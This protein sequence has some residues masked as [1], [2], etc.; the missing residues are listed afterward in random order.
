MILPSVAN[1]VGDS[2]SQAE[3]SDSLGLNVML[4]NRSGEMRADG[5][6]IDV[7][8]EGILVSP[9]P[10]FTLKTKNRENVKVFINICYNDM[11]EKQSKKKKLDETGKEIEGL[12]LPLSMGSMRTCNDKAENACIVVDAIVNTSIRDDISND[13]SGCHRDVVCQVLINCFDQKY[14]T[15]APLDRRYKLPKM[16]YFGFV[17]KRD[18]SVTRK[19]NEYSELCKQ[20][21]K[22][23]RLIPKIEEIQSKRN[24]VRDEWNLPFFSISFILSKDKEI[25][26]EDYRKLVG[27]DIEMFQLNSWKK[28]IPLCLNSADI[29]P[30]P[31]AIIVKAIVKSDVVHAMTIQ[32]SSFILTVKLEEKKIETVL[33]CAVDTHDLDCIY[34]EEK[35][36]LTLTLGT[37]STP[38]DEKPDPGS[39]QW[40]FAQGIKSKEKTESKGA[41]NQNTIAEISKRKEDQDPFHLQPIYKWKRNSSTNKSDSNE[42]ILP[43]DGFH[44][45]DCIS[46]YIMKRQEEER[47][48]KI[49]R[50]RNESDTKTDSPDTHSKSMSYSEDCLPM[51]DADLLHEQ[52]IKEIESMLK[53]DCEIFEN[54]LW[55]RVL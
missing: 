5:S 6:G 48:D 12:N 44:S 49:E 26:I 22:D 54:D 37:L 10:G 34:D 55:Y 36:E 23:T 11:I 4:P 42:E 46:Q 41:I 40:S 3:G 50:H 9:A 35:S 1:L 27:G 7:K 45:K 47:Q 17:D 25:K 31:T 32:L 30:T 21:V 13:K 14:P 43:E 38:I 52:V 24:E 29:C 53:Q 20:M 18:G 15:H 2:R 33:P 39:H 16:S 8:H 51:T 28:K 19:Q